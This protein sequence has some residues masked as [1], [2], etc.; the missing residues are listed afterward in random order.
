MSVHFQLVGGDIFV[1]PPHAV[2]NFIQENTS[3]GQN[4]DRSSLYAYGRKN[5]KGG[6]ND[7][8]LE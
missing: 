1:L 7:Q 6:S 5:N 3:L 8:W 2:V 4:C